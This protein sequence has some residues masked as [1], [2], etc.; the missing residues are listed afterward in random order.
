MKRIVN[1]K[2]ISFLIA[3]LLLAGVVLIL[4]T[5][6]VPILK[7][8][9]NFTVHIMLGYLL[10]GMF[11][12]VFDQKR[13]MIASLIGCGVLCLYLKN[14]S[15][16]N[17]R[18]AAET[19]APKLKIALVNLSFAEDGYV[20]TVNHIK[21]LDADI[22]A[23]QELT[24]DWQGFFRDSLLE[25]F[26]FRH[27]MVRI[28]PFG[29]GV[30]SKFEFCEIDTFFYGDIPN[31]R[32]SITLNEEYPIHLIHSLSLPAIN[33]SAYARVQSHFEVIQ[34]YIDTIDGAVITLGDYNLPSW[35]SELQEFKFKADLN[36]S[37]R[38]VT[39]RSAEGSVSL[40]RIPNDHIFYRDA[41]SCTEFNVIL[42]SSTSHLGIC[43]TYQLKSNIEE[44]VS[45]H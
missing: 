7:R 12:F 36:D 14:A 22:V 44:D 41:L 31:L 3:A 19:S 1:K 40:F 34:M 24:P 37:R 32:T 16:Q 8:F 18:L 2:S 29:M 9:S 11:F 30:F 43:G 45:L 42:N 5:P 20:E 4:F 25:A 10:A 17:M 6:S 26:P 39:P 33:N 15:N 13:L 27:Q 23:V 35:S 21:S 28:D 38:D